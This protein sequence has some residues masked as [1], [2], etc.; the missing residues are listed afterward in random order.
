MLSRIG[1]SSRSRALERLRSPRIPVDRIVRV[2]QEVR[3]GFVREAIGHCE[4]R[5]GSSVCRQS[6]DVSRTDT[7][8]RTIPRCHA[9]DRITA[10][11]HAARVPRAALATA[12]APWPR[13][14][15]P[16]CRSS[17]RS[18]VLDHRGVRRRPDPRRRDARNRSAKRGSSCPAAYLAI[19]PI[20]SVLDTLTLLTVAQH[21]ALFSGRSMLVSSSCVR[22]RARVDGTTVAP[23]ERSRGR[24]L[25]VAIFVVYAVGAM[26]PRPMAQLALS[27]RDDARGRFPRAHEVL[28]RRTLRLDRRRRARLASRRRLRRRVH[29]RSRDVRGRR[30]RHRVRIAGQA[31]EGTTLLQGLEA[32]YHGEHVNILSAG[33]RYQGLARRPTLR[34]VDEQALQLA[35]MIPATAPV[36][37]ETMPGNLDKVPRRDRRRAAPGVRAIEIVDGSPRGL[38]ADAPRPRAHRAPRRQPQP[39]ARHRHRTITAGDAPRPAGRCCAFRGWRGMTHRFALAPHRR[40]SAQRPARTHAHRRA[41]IV[42]GGRT[43][44]TIA[45]AGAARRRGGCSRRS[46]PTNA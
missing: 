6:R 18:L 1:L 45:L 14:R 38:V 36:L 12:A 3:T 28:A 29:H 46:P 34:D 30:A 44:S 35:S 32:F 27:D 26:V 25:L 42:A 33:R 23:R 19:A 9:R 37:I 41:T 15:F 40:H 39:R 43:P 20:S 31:G 11:P 24:V 21:I 13:A 7:H 4:K 8:A 17:S 2:L 22:V 10:S 5:V 16:G